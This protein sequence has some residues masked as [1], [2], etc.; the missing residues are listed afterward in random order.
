MA[1]RWLA[2]H[3]GRGTQG[4]TA[5]HCWAGSRLDRSRGC[6]GQGRAATQENTIRGQRCA[7]R[8]KRLC[9]SWCHDFSA[10]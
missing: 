9:V 7:R 3:D 1:A 5:A 2:S 4:A 10:V 6:A 8:Q